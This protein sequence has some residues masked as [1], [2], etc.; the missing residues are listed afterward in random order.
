MHAIILPPSTPP[1]ATMLAQPKVAKAWRAAQDFEAMAIGQLLAP[2][3]D[4]VDTA[5]GTFGGGDGEA[6]WRPMLTESLAKQMA[7]N[8]GIGLAVPV[9]Q[10]MLRMQEATTEPNG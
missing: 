4:T 9:F 2:M 1:D 8:G 5:H 10:Q 3:F 6:A 7:A